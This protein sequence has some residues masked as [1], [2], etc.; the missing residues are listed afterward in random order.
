[1]EVKNY[2]L[3]YTKHI[4][5]IG[6][7]GFLY[8]HE[9]TG[10]RVVVIKNDDRNKVFSIGFRT[11]PEDS[12]GVAH[13]LEHSVLCGSK[14]YPLKDPFVELVKGSLNTFLNAM[15]FPDRTIYPIASMNDKDFQN[16]ME[17]YLDAVFNPNIYD[18]KEIFLQE[19]W[20]YHLENKE[21][22]IY[23]N[24]VVYNEMK[25]AYSSP[26]AVVTELTGASLFPDT[27]YGVD[28]G[29]NPINIPDLTYEYFLDFHKR[30]YHPSNSYIYLYGDVD[31][32]QKLTYI[33][34]NYL[35]SYDYLEV[36]SK[37]RVQE[38]LKEVNY[39]KVDYSISK[40]EER[41]GK[42]YYSYNIC[43]GFNTDIKKKLSMDILNY[44]LFNSPA[45]N[46]TK[47][48]ISSGFLSE[49]NAYNIEEMQQAFV[50]IV[51]SNC[52]V[53]SAKEFEDKL[54]ELILEEVRKGLDKEALLGAIN[55]KEFRYKEADHGSMPTGLMHMLEVYNGILY[56]DS[57]AFLH[58]EQAK[59]FDELKTLVD[60]DYFE[61]LA[62]NEVVNNNFKSIAEANPKKD[63]NTEVE[64]A[65]K[66]KLKK[67]KASL[68]D[69]ELE[70][71]IDENEKLK[72]FQV[73]PT[74][75]DDLNKL[76][77]LSRNDLKEES[78]KL[79]IDIETFAGRPAYFHEYGTNGISY[80]KYYF[81]IGSD[82]DPAKLSIL[83][84]LLGNLDT[85]KYTYS[86]L[87]NEIN[88]NTGGIEFSVVDHIDNN[89]EVKVYLCAYSKCVD[90][91]IE[92]T[93]DL[94]SEI[95][96][97]TEFSD[98]N[99][100][101]EILLALKSELENAIKESGHIYSYIQAASSFSPQMYVQNNKMGVG[102]YDE[103]NGFIEGF[104]N[105]GKAYI[106]NL[107]SILKDILNINTS[108]IDFIG[109]KEGYKKFKNE[110]LKIYDNLA[111]KEIKKA[112]W[113]KVSATSKMGIKTASQIQYVCRTGDFNKK[114]LKFT[115]ALNVLRTILSYEYLWEN[116]RVRGGAYGCMSNFTRSGIGYLTSYRDPNL[117]ETNEVYNA[118]P[119]WLEK[120]RADEDR[121]LK[122]IIGS[123]STVD[124]PL[125]PK[126]SGETALMN[127]LTGVTYE[128]IQKERSELLNCTEKDIQNCAEHIRAILSMEAFCVIGN[129]S[130]IEDN[131]DLFEKV[132]NL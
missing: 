6:A 93:V 90:A 8:I 53:D 115:G 54:N 114:G 48:F 104:E 17:V 82:I 94:L 4:D 1:M 105:K 62:L 116:I 120:F 27:Q 31:I 67:Y 95:L 77:K 7:E 129:E 127:Y 14:K 49:L 78:E 124:R 97:N 128:D 100:A 37:I 33:A 103:V 35:N 52:K 121:M 50:S 111:N 38:A 21:D 51:A 108:F 101:K 24:G 80:M 12:T 42:A 5:D 46:I 89:G 113:N 83:T 23:Y 106:E 109:E 10:A 15:T 99:R 18:K 29:G 43:Y 40:D 73:E 47:K 130:K 69:E 36:D 84:K 85:K 68:T 126:Q 71:L 131:K 55:I 91:K 58:L 118:L 92:K 34:D 26:E 25:G 65:I 56:N 41:E 72:K 60:T 22:E 96:F 57:D 44:V 86:K 125:T 110:T 2:K 87:K 45:S 132:R 81:E 117:S 3:S 102:L 70:N 11:P 32:E 88:L 74:S 123:L 59:I 63:Y 9:K 20:H 112:Q 119:E 98:E 61:K 107:G 64:A 30:F 39:Y 75:D 66:E 122:Y 76:P 79:K 16:L 13:I 28:S 19:G